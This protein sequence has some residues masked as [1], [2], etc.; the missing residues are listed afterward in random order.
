VL[1]EL[2]DFEIESKATNGISLNLDS[3]INK[4]YPEALQYRF[5]NE[6]TDAENYFDNIDSLTAAIRVAIFKKGFDNKRPIVIRYKTKS[7]KPIVEAVAPP[8]IELNAIFEDCY[9]L[10]WDNTD[11]RLNYMVSG[12]NFKQRLG[13]TD[14]FVIPERF[15]NKKMDV[16]LCA[17]TNGYDSLI[18]CND[19]INYQPCK[20]P[21]TSTSA[22]TQSGPKVESVGDMKLHIEGGNITWEQKPNVYYKV[23]IS[24]TYN[25]TTPLSL[26]NYEGQTGK[27]IL[28]PEN[29]VVKNYIRKNVQYVFK[30][31]AYDK[32]PSS[33][34]SKII[35]CVRLPALK[36][37]SKG[38]GSGMGFYDEQCSGDYVRNKPCDY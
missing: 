12:A 20:A 36:I 18:K 10:K 22:P 35:G 5:Q 11:P 16:V 1:S 21:T 33:Q 27:I 32:N 3:L 28:S 6:E 8:K 37:P 31:Y 13:N 7:F 24:E 23:I 25:V 26:S 38:Q 30:I 2:K 4:D 9:R 34:G 29:P 15:R 17:Y 14:E 19:L